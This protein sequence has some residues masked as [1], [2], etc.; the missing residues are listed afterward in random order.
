MYWTYEDDVTLIKHVWVVQLWQGGA[1]RFMRFVQAS[2]LPIVSVRLSFRHRGGRSF[3]AL[4]EGLV[5]A[6]AG[7][8]TL[9][10]IVVILCVQEV[11]THFI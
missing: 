11:V 3:V 2:L 4:V 1:K 10:L 7:A 8:A 6:Q 5:W 9:H